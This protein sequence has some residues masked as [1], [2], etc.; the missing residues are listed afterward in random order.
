ML[1]RALGEVDPES[2]LLVHCGDLPG[3]RAGATRL[4][5]DV[6]ERTACE[7]G[8]S[9]CI[10]DLGRANASAPPAF[11][12]ARFEAAAVWPR[13]HLGKDFSEEC[14]ATAALGLRE[15]GRLYCAVRKQKGGKSLGR[16]MRALLGD[17]AVEVDA[18]DRGY[19]LW[20]G[21]RTGDFDIELATELST[22][23]YQIRDPMLGELALASRPGVFSRRELDG[24]TRALLTVTDA[25]LRNEPE[26]PPRRVVDL[27]AGIGPLGL[28]AAS[29]SSA[30]RVLAVESNLRACALLRDN[31]ASNGLAERVT[32]CEH[33]GLPEPDATIAGSHRPAGDAPASPPGSRRGPPFPN[34]APQAW[35]PFVGRTELVLLNPPTHADPDTLLRLLDVRRWLAPDGRL[36]LVV[37]RPGR[38]VELLTRLDAEIDGGERDGYFV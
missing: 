23:R 7:H 8:P 29:R 9:S 37:N 27:C 32:V 12:D 24:G 5:L 28:W 38:A 33:D 26:R 20:I 16:M 17:A 36:L 21:E 11:G 19:H 3:L 10:A 1:A 30:T 31:A 14:L 15:G 2:L 18:R 22:R 13:A 34:H 6:R 4:I 35:G 25:V